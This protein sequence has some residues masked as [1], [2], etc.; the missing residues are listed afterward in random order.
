M[1]REASGEEF[2][3]A[4]RRESEEVGLNDGVRKILWAKAVPAFLRGFEQSEKRGISSAEG[5]RVRGLVRV[6]LVGREGRREPDV[7]ARREGEIG[8]RHQE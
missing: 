2:Y 8:P 1:E 7:V 5:G 4:Y 3:V 6:A